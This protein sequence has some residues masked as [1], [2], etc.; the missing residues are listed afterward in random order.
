M[1]VAT[2]IDSPQRVEV[3]EIISSRYPDHVRPVSW[4]L[5]KAGFDLVKSSGGQTIKLVS[6][7]GQSPP[8]PGWV[9]LLTGG[10]ASSGYSWTLY[11]M[12]RTFH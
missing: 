12:P 8:H 9:I 10:D 11:G 3:S 7:G 4:D 1:N 5:R 6:D 2:A